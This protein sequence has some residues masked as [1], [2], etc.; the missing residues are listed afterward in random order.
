VTWNVTWIIDPDVEGS[1]WTSTIWV[2]VARGGLT[3]CSSLSSLGLNAALPAYLALMVRG[4]FSAGV[5]WQLPA[6]T[7]AVQ[8]PPIMSVTTTSPEGVPEEDVTV[9]V[10][11]ICSPGSDGFGL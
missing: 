11:V 6:A 1:G 9:K 7:L 10:T 8:L 4:P 2:V 5:Y 3:V